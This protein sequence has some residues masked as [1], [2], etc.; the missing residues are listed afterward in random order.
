MFDIQTGEL[1]VRGLPGVDSTLVI[2]PDELIAVTGQTAQRVALDT[3]QPRS[4]LARAT[5]GS[6]AMDVSLDGRTLLNVGWNNRLTLYDL[7]RDIVLGEPIAP[8]DAG[9]RGGYLTADGETLVT[10]LPDGI[11]LWDLVPEHQALAACA[12]AGRELSEQEWATYFAGEEQVAT[13]AV[14]AE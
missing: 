13:C 3:L 5:G 11:L 2:G 12:L 14:L 10:A 9:V 6:W 7:T 8:G 1:L 4:S